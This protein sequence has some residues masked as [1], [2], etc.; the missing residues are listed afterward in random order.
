MLTATRPIKL[1]PNL[2][3]RGYRGGEALADL[4]GIPAAKAGPED[5]LGSTTAAADSP[6]AGIATVGGRPLPELLAASPGAFFSPSHLERFGPDP[7]LLVK[8]LDAGQ[9]LMVHIHPDREYARRRLGLAHGKSEAWVIASVTRP[10]AS[11]WLGFREEVPATTLRDWV[12]RQ[13]SDAMLQA[14][15]PVPVRP[16]DA[17]YVPAGLPHAIGA[18]ILMVELQEPSDLWVWLEWDGF[19]V[20][21]RRDGHLGLGFDAALEA[22]DR[23]AWDADRLHAIGVGAGRDESRPGVRELLPA[24]AD[25]FQAQWLGCHGGTVELPPGFAIVVVLDGSGRIEDATREA[26][27][28]RRG[29]ALLVPYAAGETRLSGRLTAVRCAR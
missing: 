26:V 13:D 18:G 12:E 7:D 22:V 27:E 28:V 8:L 1:E 4:R 17:L 21:G 24:A 14:L 2:V 3:P 23:S 5:W 9:R 16:G 6:G 11:V 20:D 29:D 19:D 10:D 25:Y 15:N